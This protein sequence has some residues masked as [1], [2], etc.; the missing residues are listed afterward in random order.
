MATALITGASSGIGR[1]F[2]DQL[3]AQG[4]DLVIVA[5]REPE[6]LQVKSEIEAAAQV[7]VEILVADLDDRAQL[8][9]VADRLSDESRPIDVLVNNAGFGLAKPFLDNPVEDE[10]RLLNVLVHATL[11]LSHA[12]G[13][14]MRARGSGRII[15]VSSVAGWM[16]SG[17]Y[18]AAKS[19]VTVFSESLA[20]QL[21]GTGVSVTA[22]CPGF[23][24]THF[25]ASGDIDRSSTPDFMWV[26]LNEVVS[27]GLAAAEKGKTISVPGTQYK[28]LTTLLRAAPRPLIRSRRIASTHRNQ[29]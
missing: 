8:Q 23:V 16:A 1:E 9:T 2:A 14:A 6:L 20:G 28:V 24:H 3:A 26:P 21:A 29:E 12:A 22:V 18:A 4:Y 19:W 10:E 13:N 17:T 25:H 5:R 27:E 11:V 7:S 15:N